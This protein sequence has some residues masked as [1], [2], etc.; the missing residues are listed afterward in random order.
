[1]TLSIIFSD[2][3]INCMDLPIWFKHS[4]V[5][6][7]LKLFIANHVCSLKELRKINLKIFTAEDHLLLHFANFGFYTDIEASGK[8][9]EAKPHSKLSSNLL[10]IIVLF[11]SS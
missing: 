7:K 5:K 1:M 4:L 6:C 2:P 9:R 3:A 11:P 10:R 8:I